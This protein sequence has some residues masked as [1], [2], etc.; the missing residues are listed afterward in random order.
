MKTEIE[1][2]DK[3]MNDAVEKALSKYFSA[4][5]GKSQI[6]KTIDTKIKSYLSDRKL[7]DLVQDR[8]SK[9]ITQDYIKD[10]TSA[11]TWDDFNTRLEEVCTKIFTQSREFK[12]VLKDSIKQNIKIG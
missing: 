3:V 6:E 7:K 8:M 12:T 10:I 4:G 11:Y 9:L 1:I 2:A 5:Y